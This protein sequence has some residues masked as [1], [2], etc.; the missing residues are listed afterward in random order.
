MRRLFETKKWHLEA[1]KSTEIELQGLQNPSKK[2]VKTNNGS[3]DVSEAHFLKFFW[4]FYRFLEPKME[5]K[6]IPKRSKIE[7]DIQERKNTLQD[8]LGSALRPS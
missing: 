6:S 1:R 8:R 3:E 2:Q 4:I 7:V 5:P